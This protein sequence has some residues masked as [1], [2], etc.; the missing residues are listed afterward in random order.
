MRHLIVVFL[1][2]VFMIK[3]GADPCQETVKDQKSPLNRTRFGKTFLSFEEARTKARKA[4]ISLEEQA[5]QLYQ[6]RRYD[7]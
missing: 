2:F 1:C 3:L 4:G 5:D 7:D 6:G